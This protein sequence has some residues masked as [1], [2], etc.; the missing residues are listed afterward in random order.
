MSAY[1]VR[2]IK[3]LEA[4]RVN[5]TGLTWHPVRRALGIQ[6]FGINAYTAQDAGDEVVEDHTEE[7]LGHEEVYVVLA[8]RATFTL[9]EEEVD[10][11]AGTLVHIGDP[12]TRRHAVAREAGT[13][14]LAVGGKPREAFE[15]SAWEWWFAAVPHARAGDWDRVLEIMHDGLEQK[16][17]HPVLLYN[18][19]CYEARAGRR[20]EALAHLRRAVE[21]DGRWAA[22][23]RDDEDFASLRDDDEFLAIT[24]EA[25]AAR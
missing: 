16:P 4:I 18:T 20:E 12:A 24:R 1:E 7:G 25:N 10:A 9:G 11:P 22:Q 21:L 2:R 13:T 5:E 15:P 19:A 14:V 8:G 17:D 3:E 6:A 23:A